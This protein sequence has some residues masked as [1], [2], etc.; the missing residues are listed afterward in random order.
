[1]KSVAAALLMATLGSAH[2]QSLLLHG[3]SYHSNGAANARTFGLGYV[4]GNGFGMGAYRNSE[5]HNS[6][7]GS[8]TW[9]LLPHLDLHGVLAT[10]YSR[11]PIAPGLLADFHVPLTD[12]LS[13]HVMAAPTYDAGKLGVMLHAALGLRLP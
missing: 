12:A 4:F 7:Y 1:M 8:W 2:A 9:R 5:G 11:S 6:V 3:P 10:G 13:L